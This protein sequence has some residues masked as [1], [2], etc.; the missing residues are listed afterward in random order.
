MN[1][2]TAVFSSGYFRKGVIINI[3]ASMSGKVY[4]VRD[5][6]TGYHFDLNRH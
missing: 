6:I 5:E 3:L 2:G 1:T 4:K